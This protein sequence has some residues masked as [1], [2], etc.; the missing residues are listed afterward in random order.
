M[1]LKQ[2]KQQSK[3][4]ALFPLR[5]RFCLKNEILIRGSIFAPNYFLARFDNNV[6]TIFLCHEHQPGSDWEDPAPILLA[7]SMLWGGE[8]MTMD[9]SVGA[10]SP[11]ALVTSEP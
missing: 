4:Q 9:T 11:A 1:T 7:E 2:T 3:S 6:E 8:S 10:I 5:S